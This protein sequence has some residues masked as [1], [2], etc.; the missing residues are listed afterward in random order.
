M[1]IKDRVAENDNRFRMINTTTGE[2]TSVW[3]ERTPTLVHEEGTPINKEL[4]QPL[5]DNIEEEDISEDFVTV[6][7][8]SSVV[9][10]EVTA[11]RRGRL[12]YGHVTCD[13]TEEAVPGAGVQ[14]SVLRPFLKVNEKYA[15][16]ITSI[17]PAYA[18]ADESETVTLAAIIPMAIAITNTNVMSLLVAQKIFVLEFSF[19]YICKGE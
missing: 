7:E 1:E 11:H 14:V 12:V 2:S 18:T 16:E 6:P 9:S 15:P 13:F 19:H 17:C 5:V 8:N 3:L 4:L 10:Y